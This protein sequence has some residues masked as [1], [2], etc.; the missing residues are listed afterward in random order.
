V[1]LYLVGAA[2]RLRH[3]RRLTSTA[4]IAEREPKEAVDMHTPVSLHDSWRETRGGPTV[5]DSLVCFL[6]DRMDLLILGN[7][8]AR[9]A[10]EGA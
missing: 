6:R 3:H 9:R 1:L 7:W 5:Q 4:P 10:A 8:M 2:L